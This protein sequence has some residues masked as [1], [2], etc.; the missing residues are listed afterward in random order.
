[1]TCGRPELAREI[2]KPETAVVNLVP[3]PPLYLVFLCL[4]L[5]EEITKWWWAYPRFTA[6]TFSLTLL[7]HVV[8]NSTLAVNERQEALCFGKWDFSLDFVELLLHFSDIRCS[9]KTQCISSGSWF[10]ENS[11]LNSVRFSLRSDFLWQVK[12]NYW[13]CNWCF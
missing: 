7:P 8:T 6:F 3:R 12:D 13:L 11:T 2:N 9:S 10:D 1:M 4:P 5:I